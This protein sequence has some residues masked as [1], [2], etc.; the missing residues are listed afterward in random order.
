MGSN[1]VH[2]LLR[3]LMTA[4]VI[5]RVLCMEDVSYFGMVC[6]FALGCLFYAMI[7]IGLSALI[8]PEPMSPEDI[9]RM[10]NRYFKEASDE[11]N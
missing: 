3:K 9:I 1:R 7:C 6:W 4:A 10:R 2:Y 8:P 5:L 11:K